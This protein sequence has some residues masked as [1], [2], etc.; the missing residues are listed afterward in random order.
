MHKCVLRYAFTLLSAGS[1]MPIRIQA[2]CQARGYRNKLSVVPGPKEL[3][4]SG[5]RSPMTNCNRIY[6]HH[7]LSVYTIL[8]TQR[9]EQAMLPERQEWNLIEGR[10]EVHQ[11]DWGSMEVRKNSEQGDHPFPSISFPKYTGVEVQ[12]FFFFPMCQDPLSHDI[13]IFTHG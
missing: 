3:T 10:K 13:P 9:R 11:A 2:W 1:K 5:S 12:V 7:N 8:G 4:V 6:R